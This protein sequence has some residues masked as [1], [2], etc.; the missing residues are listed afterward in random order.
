MTFELTHD[1]LGHAFYVTLIL[2]Q[3]A[4]GRRYR[5]GWLVR[6]AGSLGWLAIGVHLG[7]SSIWLWSGCFALVDLLGWARHHR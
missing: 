2:G 4:V 3:W 5:W 1:H 7:M 6:I